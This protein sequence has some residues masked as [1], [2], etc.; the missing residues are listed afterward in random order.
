MIQTTGK[1]LWLWSKFEDARSRWILFTEWLTV[2]E[3]I[4][5]RFDLETRIDL[6]SP[7]AAIR[8]Y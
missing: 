8:T 1:F 3:L 6:G 4:D 7:D 2:T 5:E